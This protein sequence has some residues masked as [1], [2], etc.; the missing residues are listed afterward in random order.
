MNSDNYHYHRGLQF[1]IKHYERMT[2]KKKQF[3]KQV[4][5]LSLLQ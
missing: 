3:V 4:N 2:E 5:K 1:K